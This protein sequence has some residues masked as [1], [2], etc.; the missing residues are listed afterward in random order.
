MEN[1]NRIPTFEDY[2]KEDTD[3]YDVSFKYEHE[4][5]GKVGRKGDVKEKNVK[6]SKIKSLVKK[7]DKPG[8]MDRAGISIKGNVYI[9]NNNTGEIFNLEPEEILSKSSL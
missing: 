3:T 4:T 6:F 9:K 2:L 1:K 7:F 5:F 8:T